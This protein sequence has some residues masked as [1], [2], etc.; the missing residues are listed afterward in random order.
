MT[1]AKM[2]LFQLEPRSAPAMEKPTS[3]Q[4][5]REEADRF[6]EALRKA[7]ARKPDARP[8]TDK[9]E[10]PRV[11]RNQDALEAHLR[12]QRDLRELRAD[13][14]EGQEQAVQQAQESQE[15]AD[16]SA[17]AR[18]EQEVAKADKARDRRKGQDGREVVAHPLLG[19]PLPQATM[20]QHPPGLEIRS[21]GG[22]LPPPPMSG[23]AGQA[24]QGAEIRPV[25]PGMPAGQNGTPSAQ[26]SLATFEMS[27]IRVMTALAG[28]DAVRSLHAQG[29]EEKNDFASLLRLA[30]NPVSRA[31]DDK[32][33]VAPRATLQANA[34]RFAE[35]LADETGRLRVISRPGASEQ[36]RI[37]LHP[38]ELGSLD[39]R[40]VVDDRNLVHLMITTD[41]E[42]AR[43]LLREQ[44]P[45]LREALARQDLGMGEVTVHVEDGRGGQTAPEWGFQGGNAG[46]RRE[47]VPWRGGGE[48]AWTPLTEAEPTPAGQP[49]P[50]SGNLEGGGLSLIV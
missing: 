49:A 13:R 30:G 36:V 40:L 48:S 19:H 11:D 35:D 38:Q 42:A 46:D 18:V 2:S 32:P 50:R 34:P 22:E 47:F 37:T 24:G 44:L 27:G 21:A 7:E 14:K 9:V 4:A 8:E 29:G 3:A 45:Q 33:E 43:A 31:M 16:D 5:V 15:A 1:P 17:E 20:P 25:P 23:V 26:P 10:P 12:Q 6:Q 28:G 41:S 39:M